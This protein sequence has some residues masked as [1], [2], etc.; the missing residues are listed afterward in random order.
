[1][2][3]R[4][5]C[6]ICACA[7]YVNSYTARYYQCHFP[8]QMTPQSR[9]SC[10]NSELVVSDFLRINEKFAMEDAASGRTR[11][12]LRVKSANRVV[13]VI[14]NSLQ[15]QIQSTPVPNDG[16]RKSQ[17]WRTSG[18][19]KFSIVGFRGYLCAY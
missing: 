4:V 1:M 10:E 5:V 12:F 15:S 9:L 18:S 17:T 2:V 8:E 16:S 11:R 14:Q 19:L 6:T 3:Q 13:L 7:I